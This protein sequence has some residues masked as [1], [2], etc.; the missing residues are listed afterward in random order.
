VFSSEFNEQGSFKLKKRKIILVT[1]SSI[2]ILGR[3]KLKIKLSRNITDLYAITMSLAPEKFNFI[4]HYR[5]IPDQEFT[6]NK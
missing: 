6:C 5:G 1:S 3:N 4:L 2:Y